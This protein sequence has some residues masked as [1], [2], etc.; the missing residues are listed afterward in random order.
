[1]KRTLLAVFML[2]ATSALVAAQLYRW[3]DEK[4]NVE[5]RDS[6]PPKGAK[7]VEERKIGGN[8]I[9]TSSPSYSAQQAARDF[10]VTLWAYD[11]GDPCKNARALLARRG[12]PFKEKDPKEDLKAFEKLTGGNGVPVLYV[13]TTKLVGYLESDWEN[14]LDVAGYPKTAAA[15]GLK[16]PAKGEAKPPAKAAE[17]KGAPAGKPAPDQKP[18]ATDQPMAE[19][20]PPPAGQQDSRPLGRK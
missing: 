13:G 14:A 8:T 17:Q 4:G 12:V 15:A 3:V 7:K 11:C 18:E 16:P 9:E 6:P 10:P 19:A 20:P 1:M 2:A 5:Y